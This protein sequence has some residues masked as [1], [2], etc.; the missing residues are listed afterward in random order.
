VIQWLRDGLKVISDARQSGHGA[1][2][3]DNRAHARFTGLGAPWWEPGARNIVGRAATG[4]AHLVQAALG[5]LAYQT[6]T[7]STP[8]WTGARSRCQRQGVTAAFAMQ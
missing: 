5:S 6:A 4:P 8:P 2:L 1:G 7:C 3:T